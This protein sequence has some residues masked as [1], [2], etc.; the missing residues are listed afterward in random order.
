[1]TVNLTSFRSIRGLTNWL[2]R[3]SIVMIILFVIEK[4]TEFFVLLTGTID[5]EAYTISDSIGTVIFIISVPTIFLIFFW[6]YRTTKNINSFGAKHVN[7]PGMAV[8][9]WLIPIMNLWKPYE[10]AQ[11]AW[12]VSDPEIKLNEGTEWRK[13]PSSNIINLWWIL[14]LI[15]VFGTIVV[16]NIGSGLIAQHNIIDPEQAVEALSMSLNVALI[17]LPLLVTCIISIIFFILMVRKISIWH[18]L[19]AS[20]STSNIE[21]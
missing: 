18:E 20:T 15:T 13:V 19:K 4:G 21:K 9:W 10:V 5:N 1:M 2:V 14:G 6:F 8:V 7:S 12:R 16:G 17:G 11:Q 3:F